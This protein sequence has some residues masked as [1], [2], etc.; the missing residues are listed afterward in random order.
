MSNYWYSWG[1]FKHHTHNRNFN[2]PIVRMYVEVYLGELDNVCHSR[3]PGLQGLVDGGGQD[4]IAVE[5]IHDRGLVACYRRD[6]ADGNKERVA[7]IG[8]VWG[9]HT[10]HFVTYASIH[11]RAQDGQV[12]FQEVNIILCVLLKITSSSW[13]NDGRDGDGSHRGER[14]LLIDKLVKA[15]DRVCPI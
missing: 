5:I 14:N 11:N 10:I 8:W 1:I 9:I 3:A 15:D 2:Y 6:L 7:G 4:G 13:C 12:S